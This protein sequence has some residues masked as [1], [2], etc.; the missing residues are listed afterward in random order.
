[1]LL[2]HNVVYADEAVIN[3]SNLNIRSGPGT[4][5][6][7]IGRADT[8]EKFTIM[9]QQDN[10]IE[11]ELQD[12]TG[13]VSAEF[14]TITES[15]SNEPP[16]DAELNSNTIQHDNTHLRDGPSTDDKIVHFAKKGA[17]FEV[18]SVTGNW[19]EI[20][21]GENTGYLLKDLAEKPAE[22]STENSFEGKNIVI[23]AGHGGRDVGAIGVTGS[24]EKDI[25]YLTAHEL[26]QELRY[27]GAN[28][29]LTREEDEFISLVSRATYSNYADTDAFISI[30]YNSTPELPEVSGIETFYY[31]DQ[32]EQLARY[33]QQGIINETGERDRGIGE[34][35]LNVL[36]QNLQPSVLLELGFLSNEQSEALLNTNAYQ[37]KLVSGIVSGLG[38]Y[39]N[40]VN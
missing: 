28:V 8:G 37:K 26:E 12:G 19:Y 35:N 10:W 27:L 9:Q 36:R 32:H 20:S 2:S 7:S 33:I 29:L 14:V 24:Y 25:A 6:E 5:Y 4:E 23:D 11:I 30:H 17:E 22:L 16:E 31:A 3:G 40:E 1:M 18:L 13:W 21:N 15:E 39:F 38:K 34:G